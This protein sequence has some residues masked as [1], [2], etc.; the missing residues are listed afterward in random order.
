LKIGIGREAGIAPEDYVLSKF[1]KN[2][3]PLVKSTIEKAAD[4]VISIMTEGLDK[5]M[6]KFNSE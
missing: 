1:K 4:A 3:I 5:S 6:N 2:E